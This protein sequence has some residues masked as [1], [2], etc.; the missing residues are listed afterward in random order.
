[1]EDLGSG[2]NY[3]RKNFPRLMSQVEHGEVSEIVIA[4]K[5]RLVSF[6]LFILLARL[7]LLYEPSV[8]GKP[9]RIDKQ[10]YLKFITNFTGLPYVLE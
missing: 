8:L 4:H 9:A 7:A 10:G 1:M 2:L 6:G 3:K 5:D